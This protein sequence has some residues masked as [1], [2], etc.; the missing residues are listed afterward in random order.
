MS[1]QPALIEALRTWA[2][3]YCADQAAVDLLITHEAWL[4]R[5]DFHR[6]MEPTFNVNGTPIT[7]IDWGRV[8]TAVNAGDLPAS[9]SALSVLRIALSLAV[10]EPVDLGDAL[11]GLDATNTAAVATAVVTAAQADRVTV[12]LAARQLPSW[13]REG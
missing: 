7:I 11:T 13:L 9:S 12:T 6:L 5:A 3:G 2:S 4:H 1:L 8:S 10:G